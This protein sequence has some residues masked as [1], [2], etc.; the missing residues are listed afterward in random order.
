MKEHVGKSSI[1]QLNGNK[2]RITLF[3]SE[4]TIIPHMVIN[5]SL[6]EVQ[7]YFNVLKEL[8]AISYFSAKYQA[9]KMI[10]AR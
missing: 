9:C 10:R 2:S 5:K 1:A 3:A 7:A 4:I 6:E 8:C